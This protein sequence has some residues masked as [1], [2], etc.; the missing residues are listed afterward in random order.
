MRVVEEVNCGCS[1]PYTPKPLLV[2]RGC[3][4]FLILSKKSHVIVCPVL[5]AP[6]LWVGNSH[7]HLKKHN[8]ALPFIGL[9]SRILVK[10]KWEQGN[11]SLLLNISHSF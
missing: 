2:S 3:F 11:A 9:F 8:V 5:K 6:G 10:I 4:I 1:L 7:I